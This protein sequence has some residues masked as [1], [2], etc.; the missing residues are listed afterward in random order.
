VIGAREEHLSNKSLSYQVGVLTL[1][2]VLSYVVVFFV[3]IVN[4]RSLT[5]EHYGYYRQFWLL[6]ETIFPL[7]VLGFPRSLMYYLPRTDRPEEKSIYVTQAILFLFATSLVAIVI[8][9]VMGRVLGAGFGAL[10]RAFYLRLC[11]FTVF[12]ILSSYMDTVFVAEKKIVSQAVYVPVASAVLAVTVMSVSWRTGDVNALVTAITVYALAR[13][14]FAMG[15]SRRVYKPRL[16]LVSLATMKEQLSYAIPLGLSSIVITLLGQSDKFIINHFLGREALAIY[17]IGA[18]QIPVVNLVRGS[19][20]NVTFP[21][22][23]QYEKEGRVDDILHLWRRSTVALS[24]LFFPVFAV[25]EVMARPFITVLFTETYAA[26]APVF[27]IYLF[28]F[29][30]STADCGVV[31][32]AF[33][34]QAYA[35]TVAGIALVV[36]VALG[37]TLY[38]Q[39]GR[40]G[41]PLAC[42]ITYWTIHLVMLFKSA[43]LLRVPLSRVLPWGGLLYRFAVA[44]APAVALYVALRYVAIDSIVELGLAALAYFAVYGG[45]CVALRL[46]TMRE[47]RSLLGRT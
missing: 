4:T 30:T 29:L 44:C 22:M 28:I 18:F 15:Y 9:S 23:A 35:A 8:Y 5:V 17:S 45:M 46:I 31:I 41:V 11:L 7:L 24:V 19:I 12:M 1:G 40:L 6:F 37:V 39:V 47:V 36:N 20:A 21:L 43:S 14:L 3:P 2:N 32:N 33:K 16:R 34:K 27:A 13:F 42:V 26:A 38:Y 25:L 10:V